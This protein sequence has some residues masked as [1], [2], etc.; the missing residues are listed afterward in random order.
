MPTK[1]HANVPPWF[2]FVFALLGMGVLAMG[3]YGINQHLK[4][5]VAEPPTVS[6]NSEA[7]GQS[8]QY[9]VPSG[10]ENA[11]TPAFE[12]STNTSNITAPQGL[13]S[14]QRSALQN[15]DPVI[16]RQVLIEGGIRK[17]DLDKL[18]DKALLEIYRKTLDQ[19]PTTKP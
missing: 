8:G 16:L 17:S 13:D 1:R 6:G 11:T 10:G 14:Q 12:S 15:V 2:L 5:R 4:V 7:L 18:D 3:G 19:L 9:G